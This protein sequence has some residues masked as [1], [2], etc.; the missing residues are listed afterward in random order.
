MIYIFAICCVFCFSLLGKEHIYLKTPNLS[1]ENVIG[2]HVGIRPFRKTGVR[3][4]TE[5]MND[6]L[7]IHNYGYGGS[8][9]T[10]SFGASHEVLSFL[11]NEKAKTVAVLGAGVIGLTTAYDLLEKG[12]DVRIYAAEW[13]PNLTSNV[14]AGIWT[15]LN[16]PDSMPEEKKELHKR[17]LKTSEKRFMKS[18]G[19]NPE[20]AGI[21]MI[22][23]YGIEYESSNVAINSHAQG[24][25]IIIHFDNGVTKKGRRDFEIG[26]DGQIFMNDLFFKVQAN[27][28]KLQQLR[29]NSLEDILNLEEPIIVNCLSLGSREIFNDQ[30]LYPVRGQIVYYKPH[31]NQDYLLISNIS[32]TAGNYYF[33]FT[34][35]WS[36]RMILGGVYEFDEETQINTP[37]VLNQLIENGKKFFS[38]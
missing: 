5:I 3:L 32:N 28:A 19:E 27:G 16:Y 8:G 6:K 7:I 33:F 11:Q 4:E 38:K 20:F 22:C 15:P 10:L 18:V 31:A 37:E 25:E 26:M 12:Y 21:R 14:A 29:F 34:Y 23:T 1:P 17:L 2:T 36:D 9:L 24:E 35:P 30:D 13:S